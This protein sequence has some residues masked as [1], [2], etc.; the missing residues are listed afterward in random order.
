[1][2]PHAP[3]AQLDRAL[4]SEGKGHTFESCRV[5]HLGKNWARQNPPLL[6]S[7]RRRA[8]AA[9]RFSSP[10]PAH[11]YEQAN[12]FSAGVCPVEGHGREC[13][14]RAK[15][16]SRRREAL[17]EGS[18]T[19]KKSVLALGRL[20]SFGFRKKR[21]QADSCDAPLTSTPTTTISATGG[22]AFLLP[23]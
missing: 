3:V 13:R 5:R 6:R 4:P 7:K 2:N 8:C 20:I 14:A 11:S 17:A 1:M 23:S 21:H 18:Q 22:H 15:P 9:V 16:P 19:H 12:K 10:G